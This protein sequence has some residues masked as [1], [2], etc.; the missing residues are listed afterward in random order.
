MINSAIRFRDAYEINLEI[1]SKHYNEP[2]DEWDKYF[3]EYAEKSILAIAV[4][5]EF[6]RILY[7][8]SAEILN[9]INN[10]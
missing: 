7:N 5:L 3:R 4:P 8:K 10:K 6:Y 9:E 1:I 2:K